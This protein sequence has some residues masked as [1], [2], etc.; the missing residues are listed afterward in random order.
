MNTY[1][2]AIAEHVEASRDLLFDLSD[3][4]HAHPELGNQEFLAV[5]HIT[6]VL[7]QLGFRVENNVADLATAFVATFDTP[8][9]ATA[10]ADDAIDFA[11]PLTIG[12]LCEYDAL[13]K[14]GHACGHQLQSASVIGAAA[15]LAEVFEHVPLRIVVYGT[16]AEETTSGKQQMA[17]L[18]VFHHCDFALMM[19]G[20]DRTTVDGDSL[21]LDNME[22]TYRGKAAHA[23]VAPEI[24][25]SALDAV[26]IM[27]TGIEYL[28]EHVRQDVRMQGI[29]LEG[30][31]ALNIVPENAVAQFSI[32][33][34]DRAYLN[35]VVERVEK[36]A[37]GAALA[38]GASLTVRR[39]KTLDGKVSAPT[40]NKL[41]LDNAREYGAT[42]VTPPRERTGST[43]FSC[44]TNHIP[45][46]CLR[47]AFVPTGVSNH[48]QDWVEAG[49]SH[50]AHNA[51]VVAAKAMAGTVCDIIADAQLLTKIRSEYALVKPTLDSDIQA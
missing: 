6:T 3:F 37:Q 41:L 39:L 34:K 18:G 17:Q 20:G 14:L 16:P 50:A 40:L 28:R 42:Q 33:A 2:Q 35:S 30:G 47:V 23:A 22:F 32:R 15:A 27:F 38:T 10:R 7:A 13:E 24:G 51:I 43:D 25:I 29:I 21:A 26:L 11:K 1:K 31:T 12:L 46:A 49:T 48:T 4:I 36:V 5:Q 19:H 45:G 44:V 8:A 9:V